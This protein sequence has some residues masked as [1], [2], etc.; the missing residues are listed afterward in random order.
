MMLPHRIGTRKGRTICAH[1]A[2]QPPSSTTRIVAA[3]TLP[4][5]AWSFASRSMAGLRRSARVLRRGFR[6]G[7]GAVRGFAGGPATAERFVQA[8]ER[9]RV[10]RGGARFVELGGEER[11]LR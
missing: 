10:F 7:R 3:V 6:A 4:R 2:S 1:Q 5:K 8:H 9:L 11:A